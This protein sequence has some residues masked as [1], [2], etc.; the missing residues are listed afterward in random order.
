[1]RQ[2]ITILIL[3]FFAIIVFADDII[4]QMSERVEVHQDSLVSALLNDKSLGITR[5]EVFLAG[6]RVQVY[7]NNNGSVARQE[8]DTLKQKMDEA[9]SPI[10]VYEIYNAPFWKVRI[11]NFQ[12]EDAAKTFRDSLLVRFPALQ[13]ETYIVKD[14]IVVIQ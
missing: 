3:C 7:S 9:F 12:T 4:T 14:Q 11:G 6:W 10:P 1:M 8:A 2:T 13:P 5:K